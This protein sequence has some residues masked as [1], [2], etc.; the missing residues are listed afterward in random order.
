[1]RNEELQSTLVYH[2]SGPFYKV[3]ALR[4]MLLILKMNSVIMG[5]SRVL[6]KF[7]E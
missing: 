2:G 7:I 4:P 1:V 5:E 6:E 3:I